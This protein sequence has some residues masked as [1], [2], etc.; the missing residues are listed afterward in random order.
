ME[1]LLT[2]YHWLKLSNEQRH[3]M[4]EQFK[5]P[6]SS[7]VEMQGNIMK[8]DGSN[9]NDLQVVNIKSM[10]DFTGSHLDSFESLYNLTI[11]AIDLLIEKQKQDDIAES[12]RMIAKHR[13]LEIGELVESVLVTIDNLPLDAKAKIHTYL[14]HQLMDNKIEHEETNSTEE[15]KEG[16]NIQT[17]EGTR[18][19]GR[20]AKSVR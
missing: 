10:Q 19:R 17:A 11:T 12:K 9:E 18:K 13:E 20:P 5:I 6:R 7:G 2:R 16:S 8:S 14:S 3:M 4:R 15:I 1:I